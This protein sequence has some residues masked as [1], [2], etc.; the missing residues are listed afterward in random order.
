MRKKSLLAAGIAL[1]AG[2]YI[3]TRRR[4]PRAVHQS[5]P[6]IV[7]LGAGFAGLAVAE[8]LSSSR[9]ATRIIVLDQHNYQ[10]FTPLLYEAATCGII[11]YDAALP[12][13]EWTSSRGIVFRQAEVAAIDMEERSIT[14]SNDEHISYDNLVVALGSTTNFFGNDSARE[15][16][17][18]LKTME[19]GIALRNHV[20]DTLE[21]AATEKDPRVR[22][23]LLTYVVVGGGATGVETAGALAALLRQL[24]PRNY[25]VLR[26]ILWRVVVLESEGKLLGHMNN[27][28]AAIALRE[29]KAVGV[30]VRL[31]TRADEVAAD[32]VKI[33]GEIINTQTVIWATG[34]RVPEVV[35]QMAA[36]H[37]H[38]GSVVVNEFL[39]IKG[40]PEAYAIGDNAHFVDP[41]TQ[42]PVPLLAATA[43]QQGKVAALNIIRALQGRPLRA[44]HYHNLGNVVSVGQRSGV[45]EIGGKIISGFSGWL[46]WR[47]VHLARLTSTRNKLATALD[48][49]VGYFYEGDTARLDVKPAS[50]AAA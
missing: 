41:E 28:M 11:P 27:E 12:V 33:G 32:H 25:P 26:G 7:I 31:N 37:S 23:E 48:W 14:F 20:I 36:E 5:G 42:K 1:G 46:A 2:A 8:K 6:N 34:V 47:V 17:F 21:Q 45:A 18:P 22:G 35:S 19:D 13:R 16:A 24:I 29:L 50:R 4:S 43:M 44:F 15:H 3:A 40:H 49:S 38:G 39:Q 10:L 30:E 9:L